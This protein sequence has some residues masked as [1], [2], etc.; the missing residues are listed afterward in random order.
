MAGVPLPDIG[1]EKQVIL[2]FQ[3]RGPEHEFLRLC[4]ECG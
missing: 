3:H 2:R 4:Q 1:G